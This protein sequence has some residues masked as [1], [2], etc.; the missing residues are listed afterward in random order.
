ML[1][2]VSREAQLKFFEGQIAAYELALKMKAFNATKIT[3]LLNVAIAMKE[4]IEQLD[5]TPPNNGKAE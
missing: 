1:K 4:N 5:T 2:P 3:T